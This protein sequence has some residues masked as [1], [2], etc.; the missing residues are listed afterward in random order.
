LYRWAIIKGRFSAKAYKI[1]IN[2]NLPQFNGH[3]KKSTIEK[4]G[5]SDEQKEAIYLRV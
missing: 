3:F 1:M 4:K 2:L 5:V